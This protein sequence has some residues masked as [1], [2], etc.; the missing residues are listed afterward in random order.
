MRIVGGV[1][2]GL[3][4]GYILGIAAAFVIG[5]V[6]SLVTDTSPIFGALRFV[7]WA[8]ALLGAIVTPMVLVRL[9]R[10]A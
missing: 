1:L 7:A 6:V 3:V 9:S 4:G 5:Q 8:G 10:D 2:L